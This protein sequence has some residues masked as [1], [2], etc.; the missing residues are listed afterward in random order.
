MICSPRSLIDLIVGK[1]LNFFARETV[2]LGT[3]NCT[4]SAAARGTAVEE[5]ILFHS[6]RCVFHPQVFSISVFQRQKSCA[7]DLSRQKPLVRC[8]G[9]VT[10]DRSCGVRNAGNSIQVNRERERAVHREATAALAAIR[11]IRGRRPRSC[12]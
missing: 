6:F 10:P 1:C 2:S 7:F 8:D 5:S 12:I 9:A 4:F 3:E 11:S